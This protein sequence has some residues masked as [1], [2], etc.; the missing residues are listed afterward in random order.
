MHY[1]RW[2]LEETELLR[3]LYPI[4]R[5]KD[6]IDKFPNRNKKTIVAKALSLGLASAKTWQ[7]EEDKI[8]KKYFAEATSNELSKLLPKRT[9]KAIMAQGERLGLKRKRD[10]PKLAVNVNYFKHWSHNMAYILGFI[11]ADG[12]IIKGTYKGY[13]DSLKFGVQ[14]SDKDILDKIKK[15]L[16]AEHK[17]S[18]V[19]N[20]VHFCIASQILVN[21]LK[22]LG[23]SYRK[24]LNERLPAV[25]KQYIRDF[26]R[27]I[28]DGDGGI[29]ID[30][31][32]QP[33]IS[34]C[35]GKTIM[36]FMR[37]YFLKNMQVYSSVGRRSY[38]KQQKNFLYEIRYK[39][40]TALK[41]IS[42]LYDNKACLYLDR[43]YKLAKR[44]LEIRIKER[45]NFDG[46]RHV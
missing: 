36:T 12:C 24:S 25:P 23:I 34:V 18:V 33:S 7:K 41:V 4:T 37:D 6:L 32:G 42:Y 17:L 19:K 3:K 30:K 31:K 16:K 29:R 20:A 40:S 9:W 27:G 10:K 2:N 14:L 11:L 21:D 38:S 22:K 8:L 1:I 15:E 35:G 44:C 13:S 39:S 5:V 26:I 43:K 45:K 28:I 46:R